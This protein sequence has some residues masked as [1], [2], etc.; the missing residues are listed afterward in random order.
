M[1]AQKSSIQTYYYVTTLDLISFFKKNIVGPRFS[2]WAPSNRW[3]PGP[4]DLLQWI[5]RKWVQGLGFDETTVNIGVGDGRVGAKNTEVDRL[6]IRGNELLVRGYEFPSGLC[7]FPPR[8]PKPPSYG[9]SLALCISFWSIL[10]LHLLV[11]HTHTWVHVPSATPSNTLWAVE[12]QI[13][14]SRGHVHINGVR[15]LAVGI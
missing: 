5:Y 1:V 2:D 14:L 9:R 7:P 4:T 10:I 3:D 6:T 11:I 8:E 12:T 15:T 13:V